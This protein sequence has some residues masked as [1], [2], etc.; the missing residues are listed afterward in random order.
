MQEVIASA[1]GLLTLQHYSNISVQLIS[2]GFG[3]PS[4]SMNVDQM[5][6]VW[7]GIIIII[8]IIYHH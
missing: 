8:I 2:S 3:D 1:R 6:E 7:F 4:Q 5:M